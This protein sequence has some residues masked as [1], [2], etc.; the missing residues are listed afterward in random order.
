MTKKV[1]I[2]LNELEDWCC[3]HGDPKD[4]NSCIDMNK[5]FYAQPDASPP[6]PRMVKLDASNYRM[7][8]FCMHCHYHIKNGFVYQYNVGKHFVLCEP[9][10]K[11]CMPIEA[12]KNDD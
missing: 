2:S 11:E 9:C 5:W 3:R 6:E 1:L 12:A 7:G 10:F 8:F 4:Y